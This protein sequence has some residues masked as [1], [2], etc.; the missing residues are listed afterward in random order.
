M[1]FISDAYQVEGKERIE[2]VCTGCG[3]EWTLLE[4]SRRKKN[5]CDSVVEHLKQKVA[6]LEKA[7]REI[8]DYD[9]Q[10]QCTEGIEDGEEHFGCPSCWAREALGGGE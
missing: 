3:E 7:L 8:A 2:A 10:C 9:Y 4:Q 1:K 6:R 5:D